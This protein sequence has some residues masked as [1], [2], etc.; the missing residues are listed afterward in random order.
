MVTPN[1]GHSRLSEK[2]LILIAEEHIN[3]E[4][5]R[6]CRGEKPFLEGGQWIPAPLYWFWNFTKTFDEH[7][8]ESGKDPYRPMEQLRYFPWLFSLFVKHSRLFIAK[9]REMGVSWSIVAYAVWKCQFFPRIRVIVQSQKQDKA[10]ELVK[11]AG[12]PGYARTLYEQQSDWLK[13]RYPLAIRIEDMPADRMTWAN[14]STLQGVPAGADQIRLYHPTIYLADEA[15]HMSEFQACYD[16]AHPV[17][18]QIIAVSSA[19]PSWFGD[20]CEGV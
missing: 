2:K 20:I 4:H 8:Q 18:T 12:A 14:G 5:L 17:C 6:Y 16:A 10:N 9:S 13:R 1:A 19:A 7:W 3:R 15:A 11:G